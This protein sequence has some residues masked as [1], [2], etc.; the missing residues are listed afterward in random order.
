MVLKVSESKKGFYFTFDALL[1]SVVLLGVLMIITKYYMS[2]QETTHLSYVSQ[3]LMTA[4]NTLKLEETD[5]EWVANKTAEGNITDTSLTITEQIGQFWADGDI[6]L[7]EE[8]CLEMTSGIVEENMAYGI[9]IN[10]ELICGRNKTDEKTTIA[11][12]KMI[13]GIEKYKPTEGIV[14]QAHLTSIGNKEYSSYIY[15]GGF[16]GQGNVT[17]FIEDIPSG[18]TIEELYIE[19]D[20]GSDFELFI[21]DQQCGSTFYSDL[22]NMT[23]EEWDISS[24][25][26][27][28]SAGARNNFT[29][30]FEGEISESYIGGGFIRAKYLTDQ[31]L[32]G[33][34][35][36]KT[37]KWFSG[38]KGIINMYDSF[39]VPGQLNNMT[40]YL[41]YFAD[42]TNVTNN[43]L[44]VAMGERNVLRIENPDGEGTIL[45]TDSN[46]TKNLNYPDLSLKTVPFRIGFEN[47]SF[48]YIYVGQS[49]VALITD[50]SGS[51]GWR[52]DN[53][54]RGTKRN[55]DDAGINDSS[56][57]RLSIAK[58]LDKDFSEDVINITGNKIGLIAYST[59]TQTGSTLYPTDN[60]TR[61]YNTIGTSVPKT[62]YTAGG[63]T[64]ICCGINSAVD[65]LMQNI[66]RTVI[67]ANKSSGW[68]Y[69]TDYLLSEPPLDQDNRTWYN[70][71]YSHEANW[72][73]GGVAVIGYTNGYSYSPAVVTDIGGNLSGNISYADLWENWND[74]AGAP[75]DFSSG[76]LNYTANTYGISGANDGWDW[77]TQNG[78]GPFGYDDNIDYNG[79]VN[80]M[81]EF[82][83]MTGIPARNRCS[84]YDCSGAYGISVNITQDLF[85][86]I[87]STG[88][89]AVVSFNYEWADTS[90]NMFESSDQVWVKARWT[91]PDSGGHYLGNNLD[92]GH[93]GL[94][95][96]QE[97]ATA[98][99]PNVDFSGFFAQDISGWIEGPGIY[100]LEIGGK[101]YS[102]YRDEHGIWGFDNLQIEIT[103]TTNHYYLRKHFTI[104]NLSQVS[105]GVINILS[106]DRAKVYL[107]ERLI[108]EDFETHE[109]EYWNRKGKNIPGNYFRSGDNVIAVELVNSNLAAK[110]DLELLGFNSERD[111][112]I[113]AMTD[114]VAN[115]LCS[116]QGTGDATQDAIKAAC[117]AREKY[118]ITVY[119]VGFSDE[120]D[121][122]TLAAIAECGDGIYTKSNNITTL[123]QFY[124]DVASSIVAASMHSQTIDIQGELTD[125]ILYDD[126]YIEM[127]YTPIVTPPQFGEISIISEEKGFKNC[128][129]NVSIPQDLR[130]ID[131]KL[132]SYSSEHWTDGLIVNGNI[133]YNLSYYNN[134]YTQLGDPFIINVPPIFLN[135]GNN[136]F[137]LRT[138]DH[139]ENDTGCSLNNTFIYTATIQSLIPYS[140][141]LPKANGCIWSVEFEGNG[142]EDINVPYNY[143]GSKRCSFTSANV[144]YDAD[145][146]LDDAGFQIF[147]QLDF[148]DDNRCDINFNEMNLFIQSFLVPG[149]PSMWGPSIIEARIW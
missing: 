75:N 56:T 3:D 81:I 87:N 24:C 139:P 54:N 6:E 10:N 113:A 104:S 44:Y 93:Q 40:L 22:G 17:R 26:N 57:E 133:I 116:R 37:K 91:S 143:A 50:I 51:M 46:L 106:D 48:G 18:A 127:D 7:A 19:L 97:V 29:I 68:Y 16:I 108:D 141:V 39:Y 69:T 71:S 142:I 135:P 32:E 111:K 109:G 90:G 79:V 38:I 35:T 102:S 72:S 61:V 21:N 43:T 52:M 134:D 45:L 138:G 137:S 66:T 25:I 55:C 49:D 47:V 41:H 148:N 5:S 84:G 96:S 132:T 99:N 146:T 31:M 117:E 60:L 95:S 98:D 122:A 13:S 83:S 4:L 101:Q 118:G 74:T 119:A 92:D 110:F 80:G 105:R 107:N 136:I 145:D 11:S 67:I 14:A 33:V 63:S 27:L 9:Y 100:Y 77:D 1:A 115:V 131:S 58:C 144:S 88:G 130:V 12:R 73:S 89:S 53:S 36:G 28:T 123:K 70:I 147:S 30:S 120:P 112:A 15:F 23:A 20:G 126:S 76:V 124:E 114:G 8:L 103:N 125:S 149:V 42:I 140:N 85:N 2:E 59:S 78:A 121:E 64:C 34:T 65:M 82:D 62:G 94:D 86:I 129:F 128:T